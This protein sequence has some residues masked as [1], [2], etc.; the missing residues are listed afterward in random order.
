[1]ISSLKGMAMCKSD[2]DCNSTNMF[3]TTRCETNPGS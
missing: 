1:M 3:T 2:K